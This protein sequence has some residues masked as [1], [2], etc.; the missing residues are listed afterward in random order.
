MT[1]LEKVELMLEIFGWEDDSINRFHC[2][3][4][5]RGARSEPAP[6][7]DD[8]KVIDSEWSDV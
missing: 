3:R 4:M 8:F 6:T 2:L 1:E 7:W 5:L